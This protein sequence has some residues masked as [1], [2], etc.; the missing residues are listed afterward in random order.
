MTPVTRE[1]SLSIIGNRVLSLQIEEKVMTEGDDRS[2]D[3]S[4]G[5]ETGGRPSLSGLVGR[6]KTGKK[7]SGETDDAPDATTDGQE[8]TLPQ[9]T[10]TTDEPSPEDRD[11]PEGIDDPDE[12]FGNDAKAEAIVELVGDVRNLLLF[13][14]LSSPAEYNVCTN[15]IAPGNDPPEHLLL[16]TFE[17]SPD[18]RLNVLRGH[19]GSLPDSVAILNVGDATRST[20]AELAQITGSSGITIDNVPNP[21]DIQRM[22]LA[23]NKILSDWEGEGETVLCFHS[24][25][26]LLEAV[27]SESA[28]RFLNVLL[29]RVR[30]GNI[31]AHYHMDPGAHDDQT[32]GTYRPL[33]DETIR[34]E[35]DGS[36]SIDR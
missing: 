21:T 32:L 15:L 34:I 3:S 8:D 36:I 12:G 22:G 13:G 4:A 10:D 19:L 31:R 24:L 11:G 27:G 16:V 20:S 6:I 17:E 23:T 2:E 26:A 14:P 30:S 28:F 5:T 18:D 35:E 25:T 33:F 29:G 7:R 1:T 9:P